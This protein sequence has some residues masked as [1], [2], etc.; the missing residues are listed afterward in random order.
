[1]SE[2]GAARHRARERAVELLYEAEMKNR[3]VMVV[4][5][6]LPVA[7]DPYTHRLLE[8]TQQSGERARELIGRHATNWPLD[9]L[10]L[11]D[12][13]ILTLAICELLMDGAP[14]RAVVLDEAVE[15]AKTYSTDDSPGFVNGVLSSVADELYAN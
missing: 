3:S 7:P 4:V 1:V 5:D 13:L 6:A 12:R 8:A 14:P 11:L 15:L 10:A 9:R 2:L